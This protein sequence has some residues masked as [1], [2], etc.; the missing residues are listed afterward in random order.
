MY[1]MPAQYGVPQQAPPQMAPQQ[2]APQQ[3]AQQQPPPQAQ[4]EET[5][6]R[7]TT[8]YQMSPYEQQEAAIQQSKLMNQ[9]EDARNRQMREEVAPPPG[10][11]SAM[12]R[13]AT[14]PGEMYGEVNNGKM[15][16][17]K[18]MGGVAKNMA[19]RTAGFVGPVA[20]AFFLNQAL[21]KMTGTQMMPMGYG[22]PMSMP[23]SMPM[24]MG[25]MGM[26]MGMSGRG[27]G[28]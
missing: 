9:M 12:S 6:N 20:G 14:N 8:H 28:F 21:M 11:T 10:D 19:M 26:P 16:K 25:R 2:M 17:I 1:G 22:M 5:A 13:T 23:M 3:M 24:G 18:Q 15:G 27:F 4:P 7:H